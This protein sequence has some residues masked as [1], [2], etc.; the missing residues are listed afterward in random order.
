MDAAERNR[1]L[2]ELEN[3]RI[4]FRAFNAAHSKL[5]NAIE[6]TETTHRPYGAVLSG[7]TGA[8]KTALLKLIQSRHSARFELVTDSEAR[9]CT[10]VMYFEIPEE[11]TVKGLARSLLTQLGIEKPTGSGD[12]MTAQAIRLLREQHVQLVFLDEIQWLCVGAAKKIR[13]HTL[14]W[15]ASFVDKLDKPVIISGTE[16][17]LNIASHLPL[18][19]SRFPYEATLPYFAFVED[20]RSDYSVLLQSLDHAIQDLIKRPNE[21]HL[22]D[23]SITAALFVATAGSL[24]WLKKILHIAVKRCLMRD[25]PKGLTLLDLAFACDELTL[26]QS[27]APINPFACSLAENLKTISSENSQKTLKKYR[28]DS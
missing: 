7:W 1:L 23:P 22:H 21:I 8:G 18:F 4:N 20:P 27:L 6:D 10:P 13:P 26:Q 24:G 15:I 5:L 12:E 19:A 2:K 17:C 28:L 25:E 11:I 3:I 9:V 14:G 16:E